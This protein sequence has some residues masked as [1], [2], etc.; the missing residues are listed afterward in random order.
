[1]TNC[2]ENRVPLKS[3]ITKIKFISFIIKITC[4]RSLC[5][6]YLTINHSYRVPA[7]KAVV[8]STALFYYSYPQ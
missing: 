4:S 1:M 5:Y 3:S 7:S 8:E 6:E 2:G